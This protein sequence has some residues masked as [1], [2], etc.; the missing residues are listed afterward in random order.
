MANFTFLKLIDSHKVVPLALLPEKL[1]DDVYTWQVGDTDV[2][3]Y[4]TKTKQ[5]KYEIYD[6]IDDD[7]QL[8]KTLDH[9]DAQLIAYAEN[10]IYQ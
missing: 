10:I 9:K 5:F 7:Y 1:G 2:L 8:V 6:F 4:N 3:E